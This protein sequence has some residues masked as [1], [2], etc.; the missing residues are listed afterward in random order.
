MRN[1]INVKFIDHRK[2]AKRR[3]IPFLLTFDQWWDIWNCSG[4]WDNRGKLRH[5]YCMARFGDQGAYEVGNIQIITVSQN[6]AERKT[7]DKQ[8]AIL[9]ATHTGNKYSAGRAVSLETR[10]K[11]R[12]S[13]RGRSQNV[14]RDNGMFGH[15]YTLEER[16]KMSEGQKLA[17]KRRKLQ[18]L[19]E[20][21][22]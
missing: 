21:Q 2:A 11:I 3:S 12:E 17:W 9:S 10:Q 16:M 7:S 1:P 6:C 14:G 15:F 19:S 8:R 22:P 5:Q 20:T 13:L 18:T 4:H